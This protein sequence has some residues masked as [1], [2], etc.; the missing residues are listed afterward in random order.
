MSPGRLL[1]SACSLA[2]VLSVHAAY[3]APS[4]VAKELRAVACCA[5]RCPPGPAIHS[6]RPCCG[7]VPGS[8]DLAT[9]SSPKHMAGMG[10]LRVAIMSGSDPSGERSPVRWAPIPILERAGPIFLLTRSLRI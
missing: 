7:V 9:L 4:R 2:I 10:I 5:K 3:V 8:A 1:R 6:M